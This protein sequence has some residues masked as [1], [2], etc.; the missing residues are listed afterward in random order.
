M[1]A[2][3]AAAN[4]TNSD[5]IIVNYCCRIMLKVL[6][7]NPSINNAVRLQQNKGKLLQGMM[8][9]FLGLPVN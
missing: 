6:G 8:E 4:A 9:G 3:K 7:K 2:E 1:V 5:Q